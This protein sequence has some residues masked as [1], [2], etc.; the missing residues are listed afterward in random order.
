MNERRAQ[1]AA[2][3]GSALFFLAGP[4]LE[5]GVGPALLTQGFQTGDGLPDATAFRVLGA[6]LIACGLAVLVHA[7]ARFAR[8]GLGTPSP[9]APAQRLVVSGPYRFVRNP[10]YVATAAV[11]AGEA[12][13]LRQPILLIAAAV[14]VVALG[15][16]NR[17]YEEPRLLNRHG[18]AYE[19]Y[20]AAVPGWV[21]RLTPWD[22][23]AAVGER[24]R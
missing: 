17:V 1:R 7:F 12:L 16:L 15:T 18:R 8:Q 6:V 10:I 13:L 11:I 14:Y 4:G 3:I 5:A 2:A 19:T 21:P 9:A 20:R 22:P 23:D 24:D